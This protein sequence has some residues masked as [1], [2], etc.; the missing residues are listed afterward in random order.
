MKF[1][2]RAHGSDAG[3]WL[4]RPA[5]VAGGERSARLTGLLT[6]P[7][8]L[9]AALQRHGRVTVK[10]LSQAMARPNADERMLLD[11]RAQQLCM[12]REV[13][14][15]VDGQPWVF[16]HTLA[17]AKA[18][19]LLK[20]AG[21]RPLATV[22]FADPRVT[23]KALYFHRINARHPL[24]SKITTRATRTTHGMAPSDARRSMFVRGPARLLVTEV[25]LLS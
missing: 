24:R 10:V 14:L 18:Q 6:E 22:L 25:F 4:A 13:V 17:N 12:V 15:Y 5:Q 23:A 2:R 16:A 20:R 1:S 7:G 11:L 3:G 9:T 21:R 8:S 19:A